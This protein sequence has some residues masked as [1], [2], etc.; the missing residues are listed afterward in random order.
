MAL[1]PLNEKRHFADTLALEVA[2]ALENVTSDTNFIIGTVADSGA[3]ALRAC[4][5]V[6]H[7]YLDIK[8]AL[9]SGIGGG[10]QRDVF[11]AVDSRRVE[12]RRVR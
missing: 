3:N 5:H 7:H 12:R 11:G 9:Q 1:L 10:Q 8:A 4:Q 2:R 6:I